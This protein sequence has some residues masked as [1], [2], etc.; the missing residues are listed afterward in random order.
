VIRIDGIDPDFAQIKRDLSQAF[1][2]RA[3]ASA[4]PHDT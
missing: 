1:V 2:Q 4:V 3:Q